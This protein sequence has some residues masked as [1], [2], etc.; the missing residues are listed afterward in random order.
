MIYTSE[1]AVKD[2]GDKVPDDVKKSIADAAG[3]VKKAKEGNNAT[4]IQS[5]TEILS[6]EMMK[7]GEILNKAEAEK[8]KEVGGQEA[9]KEDGKVHDADF[10][11]EEDDTEDSGSEKK[12]G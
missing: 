9:P 1:Q 3:D 6:N 10:K 4:E 7:I 8:Q 5:K 11:E 12:K 2:A